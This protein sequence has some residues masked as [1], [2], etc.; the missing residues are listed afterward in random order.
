MLISYRTQE[1]KHQRGKCLLSACDGPETRCFLE[2][3]LGVE[4]YQQ[5]LSMFQRNQRGL[6]TN[7][8]S[9]IEMLFVLSSLNTNL[10]KASAVVKGVF[11]KKNNKQKNKTQK[12]DTLECDEE[13]LFHQFF[14]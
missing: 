1:G 2:C 6:H 14:F 11:Y 13:L 5:K 10:E 8:N 7:R 4:S 3:S 9:L 12:F